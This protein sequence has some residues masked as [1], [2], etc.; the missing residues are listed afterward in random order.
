MTVLVATVLHR[1]MSREEIQKRFGA[2]VADTV[3][4]VNHDAFR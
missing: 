4:V 1:K 2:E 3:R